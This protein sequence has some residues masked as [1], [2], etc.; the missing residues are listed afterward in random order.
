MFSRDHGY[1]V[2]IL[3]V[4]QEHVLWFALQTVA[5]LTPITTLWHQP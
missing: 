4:M 5:Y 3:I 2:L 1:R